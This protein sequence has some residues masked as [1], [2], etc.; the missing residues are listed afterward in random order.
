MLLR[1]WCIRSKPVVA[2]PVMATVAR[3][4]AAMPHTQKQQLLMECLDLVT[5]RSPT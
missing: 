2:G 3:S 1:T 5:V 4:T